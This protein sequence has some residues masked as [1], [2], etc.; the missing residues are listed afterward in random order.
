M[1]DNR[2]HDVESVLT[3][4]RLLALGAATAGA[5]GVAALTG[6]ALPAGATSAANG[7]LRVGW[8]TPPDVMNPFTFTTTASNEI[9]WL[10]YDTLLEYN[11][12]L[13][14]EPS[15][16]LT[17]SM[18]ATGSAYTYKLRPGV[19]WHDGEP[20]T[21][22][23][24]KYTFDI[25]AKH[26]LGQAAW[27]LADFQSVTVVN[28]HE[29]T[30]SYSKPQA[31]DPAMVIPIVPEHLWS[32]KTP[33]QILNYTDTKPVGTGP[34][35]FTKWV[36]GQYL[37]VDR[38]PT[39]WGT[40]PKVKT[41]IWNQYENSDVMVQSLAS[42]QLDILT[43][44]PPVLFNGLK[45][46]AN[47]KP[48]EMES[49]SFH[50]IGI[51]VSNNPKSGGNSLLKDKVV[52]Q[53]LGYSLDR[54]QLVAL[55]LAGRGKPGSVQL[56][57]SFGE[58]QEKIPASEQYNNDPAKAVSILEKAGYKVGAGGVRQNA[59]GEPL[60]FRLIA[61][62]TTDV[63][64][65]AGQ[66]FVKSAEAVGIKL[67]LDTLDAD[68]LN[69]IVYDAKAPNWDIFIWGW[70]SATPDPNYLLSVDLSDQIG[71][72]N[73]VYYAN[74]AYDKLY[75]EQAT[76]PN[77]AKR[78]PLVHETQKLF[79]DDCAYLIM[80]YQSKLQAYRTDTWK[81]WVPTHG[82]MIYNFTRDNYLKITPK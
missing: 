34:F 32:S 69:N 1:D 8:T 64:V 80:W 3:R 48:V 19:T 16:A 2:A 42:G 46:T 13:K 63:D 33:A 18:N 38:N 45:N 65:L 21:A 44:V 25:M 60:S 72:N 9:L 79:Y 26:N 41:I 76:Q 22:N 37:Q 54:A 47:V 61:I 31:F 7:T 15:L 51:N 11:L 62:T 35:R 30:I 82:G 27:S 59:K 43:E 23:D 75:N 29:V 68:T 74:P 36:S 39:W 53:A 6:T 40:A 78:L 20:F 58:W 66:I 55:A 4:R 50:H 17:R 10:I 77:V 5:V 24:V 56:P 67:T 14:S 73:D 12:E 57:P 28:P 70:D 81:G 71:N 49:F 52:R